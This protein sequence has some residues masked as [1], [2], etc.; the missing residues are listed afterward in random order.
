MEYFIFLIIFLAWMWP[1]SLGR[2]L[3]NVEA[4]YRSAQ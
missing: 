1:E 4:G 2:W 3:R